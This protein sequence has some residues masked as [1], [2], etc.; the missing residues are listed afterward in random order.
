MI[1]AENADKEDIN[2]KEWLG[3]AGDNAAFNFLKETGEDI[4]TLS[5]G[6]P[7]HDHGVK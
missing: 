4:Y 2:E 6:K 1:K 3:V 7:S 5:D